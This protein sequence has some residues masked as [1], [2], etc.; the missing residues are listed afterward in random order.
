[1]FKPEINRSFSAVE[2]A[3]F[4]IDNDS[5]NLFTSASINRGQFI[6]AIE[7]LDKL[8]QVIVFKNEG[9]LWGVLGWYFVSDANKHEATKA[10]WRLPEDITSGDILYLSF[11]ATKGN[12]D[13][14]GIKQMFE[15]WG[16]RKRI[17]RRRGFTKGRWYENEIYRK[18]DA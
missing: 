15:Q 14:L 10:C 9:A 5:D 18:K 7:R 12:C 6:P 3:D 13:V 17:T 4:I 11:I 1:M 8:K 2:I 16:Y